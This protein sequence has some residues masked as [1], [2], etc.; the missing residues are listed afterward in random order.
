MSMYSDRS[1][2][3]AT[4]NAVLDPSGS[5]PAAHDERTKSIHPDLAALMVSGVASGVTA[6]S[7]PTDT[8]DEIFEQLILPESDMMF[9]VAL[10]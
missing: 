3:A 7:I 10:S 6:K 4:N 5:L 8:A 2:T 1:S 9:R